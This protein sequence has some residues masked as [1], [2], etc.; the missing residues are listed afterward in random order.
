MLG[1]ANFYQQFIQ[2]FSKIAALLT[3]MQKTT[4]LIDVSESE[5]GNANSEIIKFDVCDGSKID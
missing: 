3:S 4:G 2:G 5:I 1:F